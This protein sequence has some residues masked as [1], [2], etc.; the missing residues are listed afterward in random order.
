MLGKKAK[1]QQDFCHGQ[2]R[3]YQQNSIALGVVD[4]I[5]CALE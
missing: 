1:E 3:P 2:D 5:V 4:F